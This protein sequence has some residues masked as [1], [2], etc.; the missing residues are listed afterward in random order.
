[1]FDDFRRLGRLAL[2][3][4][5][6]DT[7][8]QAV[9]VTAAY[10]FGRLYASGHLTKFANWVW[11]RPSS[12]RSNPTDIQVGDAYWVNET[13]L[14]VVDEHDGLYHLN[15]GQVDAYFTSAQL[16]ELERVEL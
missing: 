3:V 10:V 15:N 12:R 13:L 8:Q 9:T 14:E 1:M 5:R 2:L 7:R 4:F 11:T 6:Q 16:A